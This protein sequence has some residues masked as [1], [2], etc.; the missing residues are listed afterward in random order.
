M[1]P[2]SLQRAELI[3]PWLVELRRTL[4]RFPELAFEERR[5]Q[6]TLCEELTLLGIPHRTAGNTTG[7]IA[8]VEGKQSGP[9]VALRA[10]MDALPG[11][12]STGLPFASENEGV[13]HACGHDAHMT[14]VMGAAALLAKW[15]PDA[16][17]V[18][19]LFQPAEERGQGARAM[20][21]EGAL[22]G[23]E[24]I[25]AAHVGH[26][27]P[28]GQIMVTSG[29][30][31]SQSDRFQIYVEGKAGHSA[32][33]HEA[34][35]AVAIAGVLITAVQTLSRRL[36]PLHPAVVGINKV[37]AGTAANVIAGTAVLE[38]S[39]RTSTPESR[40][41]IHEGLRRIARAA[42]VLHD[43]R[44]KVEIQHGNPPVVNTEREVGIARGA[45]TE[46]LGPDGLIPVEP[47]SLG[48][49][50]FSLYLDQVPGAYVRIGARKEEWDY[51]P[52]HSPS[53]TI[54]EDALKVGAAFFDC[55][56]RRALETYAG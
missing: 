18:V 54:D 2:A 37:Q 20:I 30:I 56:A 49:E 48:A 21:K 16:G 23:V 34:V 4:H 53:F 13:V 15:P 55:L 39:I 9:T 51:V 17:N 25:F 45:V 42:G 28:T 36:N 22:E 33:P 40:A 19:F 41:Q 26:A 3:Q 44:I 27:Y 32:R 6:K 43:A 35:D 47:P 11:Q 8:R 50:D 5:T 52:L 7:I 38:G 1:E 31:T 12:E 46:T 10:D 29:A 14:M 24:G